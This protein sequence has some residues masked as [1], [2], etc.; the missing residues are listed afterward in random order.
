M[1][2]FWKI[3]VSFMIAMTVTS[4][5]AI[6]VTYQIVSRPLTQTDFEGRDGIIREVS[7]ALARGGERELKAWLFNNP[8]PTRG[9]VLLVTNERGDELLG[10]AM[11]RELRALLN[12]RPPGRRPDR[13]PN[14]QGVQ[15]TPSHHGPGRRGVSAAVRARAR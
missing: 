10:R 8:R 1:S 7:E 11:P 3:F 2:L 14:F 6:Y 9:T 12:F 5:G 4:V 13:P 15:L